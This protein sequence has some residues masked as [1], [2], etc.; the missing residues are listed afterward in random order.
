MLNL[1][2]TSF[3]DNFFNKYRLAANVMI[4][5]RSLS[6]NREPHK[7]NERERSKH[8]FQKVFK[9]IWTYKDRPID[10]RLVFTTNQGA[11]GLAHSYGKPVVIDMKNDAD[12]EL[13]LNEDQKK[14]LKDLEFIIS[15]PIFALD[16][17]YGML[18]N[19]IIGILNVSCSHSSSRILIQNHDFRSNL[20]TKVF[21]PIFLR[22]RS[23]TSSYLFGCSCLLQ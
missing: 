3:Q 15:C 14:A 8:Y 13:N 2:I 19:K 12:E 7:N 4:A 6:N 21:C 23:F 17:H 22:C 20:T 10:K 16:D 1:V 11:S 9:V 18:S 5:K